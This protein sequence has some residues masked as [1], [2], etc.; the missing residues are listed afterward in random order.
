MFCDF[1]RTEQLRRISADDKAK[2]K[3]FSI[4]NDSA[5]WLKKKLFK[6]VRNTEG[7]HE[8]YISHLGLTFLVT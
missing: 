2:L 4:E 7:L 5:G 8:E 1:F 6:K 3:A